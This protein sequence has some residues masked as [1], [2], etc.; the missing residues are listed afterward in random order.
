MRGP[1][2]QRNMSS[3]N[4]NQKRHKV[5]TPLFVCLFISDTDLFF[6]NTPVS[7]PFF[8]YPPILAKIVL[9]CPINNQQQQQAGKQQQ[10]AAAAML[11][12][13]AATPLVTQK[14][15]RF[16]F[17]TSARAVRVAQPP[18]PSPSSRNDIPRARA[19]RLLLAAL[20]HRL[21]RNHAPHLR[22]FCN[23]R[24]RSK[25]ARCLLFHVCPRG[26]RQS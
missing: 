2:T 13:A 10:A 9:L 24:A 1:L 17:Q 22:L 21:R 26:A 7:T 12:D 20:R 14:A 15:P 6:Y 5:E 25:R 8:G 16:P 3:L 11:R 18:P 23:R 19:C 4:L